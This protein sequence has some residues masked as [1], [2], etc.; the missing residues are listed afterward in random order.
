[1]VRVR[2]EGINTVRKRLA[3]GSVRTYHYHRASGLRINGVPGS[4][5]FVASYG[6]AEKML[7]DRH[8]SGSLNAL[9]RGYTLSVEFQQK[10]A[11]STQT[12]YRRMLTAAESVRR[13]I[14]CRQSQRC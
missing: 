11:A 12:E 13:T 8:I 6:E 4:A 3:D 10:L 5:E 14:A 1:V 2:L 7:R 9:V